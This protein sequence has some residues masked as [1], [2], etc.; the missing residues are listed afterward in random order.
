MQLQ[1][2][3]SSA[4]D[5][6]TVLGVTAEHAAELDHIHV[7]TAFHRAVTASRAPAERQRLLSDARFAALTTQVAFQ[8]PK[9]DSQGARPPSRA[10]S[11]TSIP[12]SVLYAARSSPLPWEAS[13][14]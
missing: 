6:E 12:S 2:Q 9:L 3:L 5:V 13:L 4:T 8:L 14:A 1:K 11:R 7:S 10:A